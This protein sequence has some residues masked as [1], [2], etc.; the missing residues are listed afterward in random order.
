MTDLEESRDVTTE[1]VERLRRRVAELEARATDDERSEERYRALFETMAQGVVYQAP[2]GRIT[3]ANPAAERILGLSLEQMQGRSSVDPRWR[4]VREDGSD[5]SGGQ[6]PAMEALRTGKPVNGVTMGVFHPAARRVRWILIDA[7]PQFL[8]GETRPHQVYATFTDITE[9]RKAEAALK[10]AKEYAENL[11]DTANSIVVGMDRG[12][13]VTVFN[14]AAEEITGYSRS[15]LQGRNWFEVVVPKERYPEVWTEFHR[16]PA[17]GMPRHFE[18]PVLTKTGEERYVVWQN[19]AISEAGEITGTISFGIDITERRKAEEH[20]RRRTEGLGILLDV[21]R[22]LAATLDV[23]SVLQAA[24]DGVTRL[25]GLDTAAVYLL[26]GDTLGL[27]A[28]T[29]PLPPGFPEGLRN[30]PLATHPHIGRALSSGLPL[31]VPDMLTADLTPA[32]RAVA[33]QRGLRTVLFL[34]LA[35]RRSPWARS[36]WARSGSRGRSGAE[37]DLCRTLAN[38]AALAVEN[39]R[40]LRIGPAA[41]LRAGAA[42]VA[43][44]RAEPERLELE[45]RLLHAQK[46][47]S[48]GILAGGIAHDF[49]NLLMAILGN[50]DLALRRRSRRRARPREHRAGDPGLRAAPRT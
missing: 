4:A 28:T 27:G 14:R 37:I 46:L 6:H 21:S 32:E 10:T 26:E 8:P 11:I 15:E 42:I 49:N 36:S 12:G 2:D 39:A 18:N 16:L 24:T 31:F 9:R 33:E 48:L 3:S 43:Q 29:P 30:A 35:R 20:L 25:F 7:V 22:N 13:N 44:K 23:T 19:N 34:P 50:L 40:L 1:D 17:G 5:F 38:L 41:R 45:R 47:E